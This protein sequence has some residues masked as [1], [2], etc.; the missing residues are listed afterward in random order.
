MIV[1][2]RYP[3]YHQKISKKNAWNQN[4]KVG[5]YLA[6]MWNNNHICPFDEL[7]VQKIKLGLE[8]EEKSKSISKLWT[9]FRSTLGTM[10]IL[11]SAPINC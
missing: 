7:I 11:K 4:L 5:P 6:Y 1:L 9:N 3:S 10:G 8:K 2:Q